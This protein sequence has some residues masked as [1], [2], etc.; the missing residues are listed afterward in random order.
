MKQWRGR[1]DTGRRRGLRSVVATVVL[2]LLLVVGVVVAALV[3]NGDDAP[4]IAIPPEPAAPS[5]APSLVA[6]DA[7]AAAPSPAG[8]AQR[9]AGALADPALGEL[10]GVV[11]DPLTGTVLW[12]QLPDTLKTPASVTKVLTA[13]AALLTLPTDARIATTVR[14]GATPGQVVLVGAGDPTLAPAAVPGQS[15]AT[16]GQPAGLYNN[17]GSI[18]DLAEQLTAL[19]TPITSVIVDN[20]FYTGPATSPGW[21]DVDIDA[22]YIAPV[23]SV[24]IDGGRADRTVNYSPR[25]RTPA[26]DAGRALAAA[27]GADPAAV[28]FGSAAPDASTLATT[29]S[30]PLDTRLRDMMYHS[31]N[32]LAETIGIEVA[33]ATGHPHSI[34]GATAAILGALRGAGIALPGAHL[35]DASGLSINDRLSAADL[36]SVISAATS[37]NQLRLRP[38][39]DYLPIA[40]ATGSLV[41]RYVDQNRAGAGYVRAKTGTLD[42]VSTLAGT[43]LDVD[44]RMLT[45]ALM[46]TGLNPDTTRPALDAITAALRGCGCG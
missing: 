19:G 14:A 46:S 24:M 1:R 6:I 12:S 26:L 8:T 16:P 3:T 41:N 18:A 17:P 13:A 35:D 36:N 31:D 44:G 7:A 10:T 43:V 5:Y 20:G 32:L 28:A 37:M 33:A 38:L 15:A 11:T 2:A 45:F 22:G 29:Y 23:E 40:G 34:A 4:A 39:L 30:A 42:G 9:L 25:S 21:F 27:I